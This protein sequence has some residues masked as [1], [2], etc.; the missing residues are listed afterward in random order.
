VMTDQSGATDEIEFFGTPTHIVVDIL[1]VFTAPAP[2]SLDCTTVSAVSPSI[3][4]GS[5]TFATPTCAA[6]FAVTGGGVGAAT[7][8]NQIVEAS[9]QSGNGWFSAVL[10]NSGASRVYTFKANCCRVPGR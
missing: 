8:D 6:G 7:N 4:S 3:P 2:S 9:F 1:G 5:R 10:N